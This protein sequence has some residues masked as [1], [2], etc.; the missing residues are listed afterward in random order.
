MLNQQISF[1]ST[2]HTQTKLRA[3]RLDCS[4][5]YQS[6]SQAQITILCGTLPR[7]TMDVSLGVINVSLF[8]L[9]QQLCEH[10]A[11]N[12]MTPSHTNTLK[13]TFQAP[14]KIATWSYKDNNKLA[15]QLL[16]VFYDRVLL[17]RWEWF[18]V[19]KK[20]SSI[21]SPACKC[22]SPS[23][24]FVCE[25]RDSDARCL[26][27]AVS[28]LTEA[29]VFREYEAIFTFLSLL[30]DVQTDTNQPLTVSVISKKVMLKP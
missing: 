11:E 4:V 6:S 5:L 30:A 19:S 3:Q 2:K 1:K 15:S 17:R 9:V 24:Q 29:S 21:C 23:Y 18:G 16:K 27:E 28:S 10:L 22:M 26:V 13:S 25:G 14:S 12:A 7:F 20:N 8:Q